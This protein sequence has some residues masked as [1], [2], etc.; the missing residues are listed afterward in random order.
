MLVFR[1]PQP[2]DENNTIHC[3]SQELEGASS[4]EITSFQFT[5]SGSLI[6]ARFN[7]GL[8]SMMI[9][10]TVKQRILGIPW[11]LQTQVIPQLTFSCLSVSNLVLRL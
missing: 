11:F 8:S 2:L 7:T 6:C 9:C 1:K 5:I 3:R 4:S 10:L